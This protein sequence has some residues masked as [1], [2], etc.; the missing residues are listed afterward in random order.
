M[1]GKM[2]FWPRVAVLAAGVA[3]AVPALAR[4]LKI[5]VVG[6]NNIRGKGVAPSEAYPA[7]L[8]RLLRSRGVDATVVNAGR[9][10]ARATEVLANLPAVVP[11]D[12][13]VS[14]VSIGVNDVVYDHVQPDAS[15]AKCAGDRPQIACPGDGS[16]PPAHGR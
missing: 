3:C 11:S 4:P 8:E 13:D 14:V 6:D 1:T 7:R 10:R 5:V 16:R 15:R 12:T 2:R 9:N